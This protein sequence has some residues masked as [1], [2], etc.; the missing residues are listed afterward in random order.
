M[1][2]NTIYYFKYQT[3][4]FSLHPAYNRFKPTIQL[5]WCYNTIPHTRLFPTQYTN[6]I[7]IINLV[8]HTSNYKLG[9][10]ICG[11]PIIYVNSQSN[12]Y[13]VLIIF[14]TRVFSN[15]STSYI[16]IIN[17]IF[18]SSRL[19]LFQTII[20]HP[21]PPCILRWQYPITTKTHA[22]TLE[23]IRVNSQKLLPTT[24]S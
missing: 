14:H 16:L 4:N 24:L 11:Q 3:W 2:S 23:Y 8:P 21:P 20:K 7:L 18:S 13:A 19:W 22:Q 12:L 17:S 1:D 15:Q 9:I 6:Y 10:W 5:I